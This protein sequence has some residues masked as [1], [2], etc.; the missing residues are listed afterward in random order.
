MELTIS[1]V[2]ISNDEGT[3]INAEITNQLVGKVFDSY[4]VFESTIDGLSEATGLYIEPTFSEEL[5]EEE[6]QEEWDSMIR[7][8]M[9]SD[10][11]FDH[12]MG[13]FLGGIN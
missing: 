9:N 6:E 12:V 2:N 7:T 5:S 10:R 11:P 3:V 13:E 4:D 1:K 8:A